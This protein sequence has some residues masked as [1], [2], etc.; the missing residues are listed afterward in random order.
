MEA[1]DAGKPFLVFRDDDDQQVIRT[2]EASP[3]LAGRNPEAFVAL[4]WDRRV[5]WTHAQLECVGDDWCVVDDG[6]ST[7]G[8]FVNRERIGGRKRLQHGD[9]V[10]MGSTVL[11]FQSKPR[12]GSHVS[13]WEADDPPELSPAQLRVLVALC[14]PFVHHARSYAATNREIADELFISTVTVKAHLRALYELFAIG[15]LPQ[16]RK[17]AELMHRAL[18]SGAVVAEDYFSGKS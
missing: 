6:L 11:A 5:S 15:V 17:R 3:V 8:T 1:F 2:L 18:A 4:S 13:T 7:N 9:L 12:D 14:R 16:N 10:R